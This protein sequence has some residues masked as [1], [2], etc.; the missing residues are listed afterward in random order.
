MPSKIKDSVWGSYI[1]HHTNINV[2]SLFCCTFI[3]WHTRVFCLV[4]IFKSTK[5]WVLPLLEGLFHK[6]TQSN[7]IVT[8][9]F[10]PFPV[11]F[12]ANAKFHLLQVISFT[13]AKK[14]CWK[15]KNIWVCFS[16]FYLNVCF[17]IPVKFLVKYQKSINMKHSAYADV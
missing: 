4:G 6:C 16:F 1:S 15:S 2:L 9:G 8:R 14:L 11:H 3:Y 5:H 13:K 12:N 10:L 17:I 7:F